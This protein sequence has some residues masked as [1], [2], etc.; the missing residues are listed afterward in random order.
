MQSVSPEK[1]LKYSNRL[2]M[3]LRED[4]MTTFPYFVLD[5]ELKVFLLKTFLPNQFGDI[6]VVKIVEEAKEA[7]QKEVIELE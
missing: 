2:K 7:K 3:A 4:F 5:M 1:V 6:E